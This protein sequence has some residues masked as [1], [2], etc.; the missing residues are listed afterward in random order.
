ML[1]VAL[2]VICIPMYSLSLKD[3]PEK[4]EGNF[5]GS[6]TFWKLN[7]WCAFI[8][9]PCFSSS[10][11]FQPTYILRKMVK[12]SYTTEVKLS[13]WIFQASSKTWLLLSCRVFS[14]Q[15]VKHEIHFLKNKI[16]TALK[17]N[18]WSSIQFSLYFLTSRKVFLSTL[19]WPWLETKTE[20]KASNIF[21]LPKKQKVFGYSTTAGESWM[22]NI[23][24]KASL[25]AFFIFLP[26]LIQNQLFKRFM[27]SV[28]DLLASQFCVVWRVSKRLSTKNT[29]VTWKC[30]R[31]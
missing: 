27:H 24:S 21:T 31:F 18:L 14:L 17:W 29:F 30:E 11:F 13:S 22:N 19:K 26:W 28:F 20:K 10:G 12:N 4:T 7:L 1:Y 9:S 5:V 23:R 8:T 16:F 3:D 2:N 25:L 6:T 15:N